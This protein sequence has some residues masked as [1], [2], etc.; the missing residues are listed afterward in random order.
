M[1]PTEELLAERGKTH[2]KFEHHAGCT[3]ELKLVF[4]GWRQTAGVS[5]SPVQQE[6]VDMILHKLGRIATGKPDFRD[7][8]D[9]IAGYATLAAQGGQQ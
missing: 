5:L 2:G 3:Q 8:W 1:T 6:A 4:D 9:D 7:H